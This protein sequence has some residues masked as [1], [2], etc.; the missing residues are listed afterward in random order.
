MDQASVTQTSA[1]M[2]R[3]ACGSG[4]TVHYKRDP[5]SN[6]RRQYHNLTNSKRRMPIRMELGKVEEAVVE[7][8]PNLERSIGR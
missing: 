7:V 4:G 8:D 3:P 5:H 2:E 6:Q 1:R